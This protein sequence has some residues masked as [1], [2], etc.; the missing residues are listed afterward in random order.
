MLRD[1]HPDK[2]V[3]REH[4]RVKHLLLEKYLKAWMPILGRWNPAIAYFDGFAGRGEYDDG[5]IRDSHLFLL[6]L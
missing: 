3:C 6:F 1:N 2:W 5:L 4:T